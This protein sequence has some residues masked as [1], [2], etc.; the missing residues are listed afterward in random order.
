MRDLAFIQNRFTELHYELI[1]ADIIELEKYDNG[2]LHNVMASIN[3]EC[4]GVFAGQTLNDYQIDF[5]YVNNKTTL[6][7]DLLRMN[8]SDPDYVQILFYFCQ[9]L[10]IRFKEIDTLN[11][12]N[13]FQL[14]VRSYLEKEGFFT[15][16]TLELKR[17]EGQDVTMLSTSPKGIHNIVL[18]EKADY[19]RKFF[20]NNYKRPVDTRKNY[21]YLMLNN[22]TSLIKIGKS[23][24]PGYRERTL[25]SQ[26]P[27]IYIIAC[28]ESPKSVEGELHKLFE[29]KRIR[30]EWFR[31][32]LTDLKKIEIFMSDYE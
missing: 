1:E 19:Y 10:V 15:T 32:N 4:F 27:A 16:T 20:N 29:Q 18:F 30:G 24:N 6:T 26:E 22:D 11:T 21:T 3:K 2:P 13:T 25:H 14:R 7:G 28:W 12:F 5:F 8:L 17:F 23:N 9:Y 31:L